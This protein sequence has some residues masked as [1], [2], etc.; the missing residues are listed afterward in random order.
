MCSSDIIAYVADGQINRPIVVCACSNGYSSLV[1]AENNWA[2]Y[3]AVCLGIL[4]DYVLKASG[5]SF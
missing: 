3:R 1:T 2:E 4:R 5:V